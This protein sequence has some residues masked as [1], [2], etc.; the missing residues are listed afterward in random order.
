M[1][2]GI[3]PYFNSAGWAGYGNLNNNNNS[4]NS[5]PEFFYHQTI[6]NVKVLQKKQEINITNSLKI[7]KKQPDG[8]KFLY[9]NPSCQIE[10]VKLTFCIYKHQ[11]ISQV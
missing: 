5:R 8:T 1:V 2:H 4:N 9:F 7:R 6:K 10:V 3:L 11:A